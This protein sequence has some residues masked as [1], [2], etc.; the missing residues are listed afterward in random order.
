MSDIKE[1]LLPIP[2]WDELFMRH[3]YLIASKSKDQ[4]TQIGAILVRDG[5]LISEGYNGICRNVKDEVPERLNRPEKYHWFEHG[6]RNSIYNAARN[7][8]KTMGSVM[9]TQGCPCSDCGRAV[10]QAGIEEI[11]LHTPWENIWK[12]I[13]GVKWIDSNLKSYTMFEEANI[14]VR[15]FDKKLNIK[16]LI[17]EKIC[18]V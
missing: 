7:G 8:I 5:I 13:K 16:C 14:K 12:E 4:S 15:F 2:S 10:I 18:E 6:E 17:S 1:P 3:A 9:Y 11:V